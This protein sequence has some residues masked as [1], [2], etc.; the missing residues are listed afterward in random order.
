[1]PVSSCRTLM[2]VCPAVQSGQTNI[3]NG[4]IMKR[5][6]VGAAAVAAL[7]IGTASAQEGSA[8]RISALEKENAAIRKEIA[9]LR[10]NRD[11]QKQA[12]TL[13]PANPSSQRVAAGSAAAKSDPFAAYAADLPVAYKAAPVVAQQRQFRIWGEGGA[14]W[15]GGDPMLQP[16]LLGGGVG[17]GGVGSSGAGVFDLG[18][19][20]GWEGAGGFDYRIANSAWHVSGQFRYGESGKASGSS[21]GNGSIDPAL[22][23]GDVTSITFGDALTQ[24]YQEKRWLAD[25]AIGRDIAGDGPDAL[26]IKGGLRVAESVGTMTTN[27]N[28][29]FAFTFDPPQDVGGFPPFSSLSSASVSATVDRRSFLGAGPLIGLEGCIP[30]AGGWTF[31]YLGDAALLFGTQKVVSSN[32]TN[33]SI[34][35]PFLAGLGGGIGGLSS[36][37]VTTTERFATMFSADLQV[38]VSYWLTQN[39]KLG[40]S[41]RMDALINVQNQDNAAVA[42]FLADRYTHGPRLRLTGQF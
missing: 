10:E 29:S 1:M 2:Q 4:A 13:K 19:K 21:T 11:L 3:Q 6:F 37:S 35:P 38:G 27:R 14:I 36:S 28:Q 20:L 34:D 39:L 7:S 41:Y 30:L 16:Y 24:S 15:S 31:D 12:S 9:L 33:T 42:T 17:L 5:T 25:L 23:G 22:F 32:V 26:Q 18:P 8:S 40:L